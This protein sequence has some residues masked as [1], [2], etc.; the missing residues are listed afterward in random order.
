MQTILSETT[1]KIQIGIFTC[2][3][4]ATYY[5]GYKCLDSLQ[6]GLISPASF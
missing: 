5:T 4:H 1:E 3:F 6:L 2:V